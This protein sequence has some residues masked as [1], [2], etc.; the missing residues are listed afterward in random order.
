MLESGFIC[1]S[2]KHSHHNISWFPNM[3]IR[4]NKYIY[5][6]VFSCNTYHLIKSRKHSMLLLQCYVILSK[7]F[8]EYSHISHINVLFFFFPA[9]ILF[10][11]LCMNMHEYAWIS[12]FCPYMVKYGCPRRPGY[13][14]ENSV[15]M[16]WHL[17]ISCWH[18]ILNLIK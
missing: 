17:G 7:T 13:T 1:L 2:F 11:D 18:Q 5:T 12:S 15:K 9:E 16:T 14:N 10:S 8:Q 6:H 4:I 3:C